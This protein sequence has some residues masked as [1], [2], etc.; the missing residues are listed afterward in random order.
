M[1]ALD[2]DALLDTLQWETFE[3][4]LREVNPQHG[5]IA[6]KTRKGWPASTAAD[7]TGM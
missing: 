6:D 5:L 3:Y 2:D 4:F 1:A 7:A